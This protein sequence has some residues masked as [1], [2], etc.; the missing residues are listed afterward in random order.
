MPVRRVQ[1]WG[2]NGD[3]SMLDGKTAAQWLR[4]ARRFRRLTQAQLAKRSGISPRHLGQLERGERS[5]T[6]VTTA[7]RLAD[8][9]EIARE[10]VWLVALREF[11]RKER[12]RSQD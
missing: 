5:L 7:V 11:E 3:G 2:G 6:T 12:A 1:E 4:R 10:H 8:G 9:L